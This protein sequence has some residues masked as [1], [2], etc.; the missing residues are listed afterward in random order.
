MK[1]KDLVNIL[2]RRT[3]ASRKESSDI[4]DHFF[5]TIKETIKEGDKVELRGFGSFTLRSYEERAGRNP[6]TGEEILIRPK[7]KPHFKVG[8]ELRKG[9]Q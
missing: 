3:G 1:R 9:V 4:V 8:Q 5:T 7:K 2:H 6:K